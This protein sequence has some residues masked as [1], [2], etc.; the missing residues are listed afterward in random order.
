MKR[1]T[2]LVSVLAAASS[3]VAALPAGAQSGTLPRNH[4]FVTIGAIFRQSCSKCHPWASS[5]KGIT[6]PA[7]I[8]ALSP[9]ESLLYRQVSDGSMPP[10]GPK[11][12]PENLALIRA[13]LVAGV[14][15]T[16]SP[17]VERPIK[18]PYPSAANTQPT[19]VP[20]PCACGQK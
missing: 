13:W 1:L 4:G 20:Q 18:V 10:S 16:D 12:R 9:E 15:S 3:M 14:P 19:E 17:L 11:L 2:L 6:Q 5:Y 8:V 7:R